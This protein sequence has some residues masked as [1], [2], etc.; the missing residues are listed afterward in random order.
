LGK[1]KKGHGIAAAQSNKVKEQSSFSSASRG[2]TIRRKYNG[3]LGK[4]DRP[5]IWGMLKKAGGKKKAL[6][7]KKGSSILRRKL[8]S[9]RKRWALLTNRA[10]MGKTW[11]KK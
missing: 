6:S 3:S 10:N 8:G 7:E 1:K 4:S 5:R 9:P 11:E 2:G